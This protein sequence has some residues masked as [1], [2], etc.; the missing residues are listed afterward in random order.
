M[1]NWTHTVCFTYIFSV[2]T[3]CCCAAMAFFQVWFSYVKRLYF[4]CHFSLSWIAHG[5]CKNVVIEF[6][7]FCFLSKGEIKQD[8]LSICHVW[9]KGRFILPIYGC[10]VP[11]L[12]SSVRRILEGVDLKLPSETSPYFLLQLLVCSYCAQWSLAVCK[13]TAYRFFM[14]YYWSFSSPLVSVPMVASKWLLR[15]IFTGL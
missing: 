5:F 7:Q 6:F 3:V 8:F 1:I 4:L 2:Y 11:S 9:Q 12:D 15:L 13:A 14:A 10:A